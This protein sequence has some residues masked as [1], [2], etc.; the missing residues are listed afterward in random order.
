MNDKY[1]SITHDFFQFQDLCYKKKYL[2]HPDQINEIIEYNHIHNLLLFD[3]IRFNFP[4][5]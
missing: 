4:F 1:D 3:M 5:F 2:Q